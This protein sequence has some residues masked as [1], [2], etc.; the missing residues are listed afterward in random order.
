MRK[1]LWMVA[2]AMMTALSAQAQKI[3]VMDD[4]GY[5]IP[6]VS[7]QTEDGILIGMTDL[8][9]ELADVKGAAKVAVT[10]VAYKPKL[11]TVS[12]LQNGRIILESVDF[13]LDEVV[14]KP[15][16]YLYVEYYFRAFSYIDDSLRV[17]T[18]GII[19]V[20]HEIQNKYKGKTHGVWAF[21]GAANKALTW[22][23]QDL[24]I[25]GEKAAKQAAS[26][27]EQSIRRNKKFQDYYKIGFEADG[28]NKWLVK[29]PEGVVGNIIHDDG[30][31]I[32]TLDGGRTQI[33]ANK[34]NGEDKQAKVREEKNYTYQ[35]TEIFKLDDEGKVQRQNFVM[36]V[37]HWEH[38]AKKG[39]KITILY[40]Y[41]T[42]KAYYDEKEF[43]ERCKELNK[44]RSGDMSLSEL[45]EYERA[46][47]IPA[48]ST[49]QQKAI[50]TLTKQTGMKK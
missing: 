41:A 47:N 42:D 37:D 17:Y 16:P 4:D 8:N 13:G 25:L 21:G 35:Y 27:I 26:S 3:V 20:G 43:K 36:A 24:Q 18:A 38:D 40:L 2:V 33:Y 39:K 12:S 7:V 22:N 44:G 9:G 34:V 31:S 28:E 49:E 50:Q 32:T 14:V 29:N 23:T 10:H 15:K 46:H 1:F 6:L 19:P 11:L 30:L 45:A 48:L 5:G